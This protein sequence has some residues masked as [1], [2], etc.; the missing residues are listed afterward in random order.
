MKLIC[1]S[2]LIF[3]ERLLTYKMKG[4]DKSSEVKERVMKSESEGVVSSR[5]AFGVG[6]FFRLFAFLMFGRLI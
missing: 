3:G 1:L 4:K 6:R 5:F 2:G